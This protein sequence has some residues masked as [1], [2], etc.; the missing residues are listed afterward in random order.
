MKQ[1]ISGAILVSVLSTVVVR[2]Q[3]A[4]SGGA[5]ELTTREVGITLVDQY[6]RPFREAGVA[7]ALNPGGSY[8]DA[9]AAEG[10]EFLVNQAKTYPIRY[11]RAMVRLV[12]PSDA[13]Q[14]LSYLMQAKG[15]GGEVYASRRVEVSR[16]TREV[17]LTAFQVRAPNTQE[18]TLAGVLFTVAALALVIVT[19]FYFGF[20][21]M[22]F[23]RRMEVASA[24]LWSAILTLFYILVVAGTISLAYFS[25]TLLTQNYLTSYAGLVTIFVGIYLLGFVFL[26]LMTRPQLE[27]S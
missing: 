7:V 24:S 4:S 16:N 18:E 1:L 21:R 11:G 23:N 20:R 27:R 9:V 19:F 3:V 8:G 13:G 5:S 25:P 26:W 15:P 6:G 10:V 2:A 17:R 12:V 14:S 22:L